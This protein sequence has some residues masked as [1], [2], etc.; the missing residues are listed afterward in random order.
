MRTKNSNGLRKKNL[1]NNGIRLQYVLS[2]MQGI[3][4]LAPVQQVKLW[5]NCTL[6]KD[7]LPSTFKQNC[8]MFYITD[9]ILEERERKID[10]QE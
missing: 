6:G 3:N 4:N 10:E 1:R 8:K 7:I 9:Y 2:N 5:N